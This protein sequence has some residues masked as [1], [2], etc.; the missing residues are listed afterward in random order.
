MKKIVMNDM[1]IGEGRPKVCVPIVA[2]TVEE[3]IVQ[4][5]EIDNCDLVE[6]RGDYIENYNNADYV[7]ELVRNVRNVIDKPF[8]FTFRTAE[9]GG[10]R[11]IRVSAYVNILKTMIQS[12]EIQFVDVEFFSG[13]NVVRD[14]VNFAKENR[15]VTIISNHDF[16]NTPDEQEMIDR[17][18]AMQR[19]G[20]D[21]AKIAVMPQDKTDVLRL[22]MATEQ[23]E[24]NIPVITMSMGKLGILSR[25]AGE[26]TGSAITFG[27]AGKTSA[28]GQ[29]EVSDLYSILELIHNQVQD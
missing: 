12:G 13:E 2:R 22:M 29:V 3:A 24:L 9:E 11:N 15:V 17:L 27:A 26:I 19:A 14:I 16:N 18:R 7:I 20:A 5:A 10:E 4:A 23:A 25:I 28:P 8:I 1:I 6:I 21:I